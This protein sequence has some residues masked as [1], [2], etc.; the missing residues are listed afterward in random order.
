[1]LTDSAIRRLENHPVLAYAFR[2]VFLLVSAYMALSV[3][4]WGLFWTGFIPVGFH[5]DPLL[6]HMYE[7]I[8]GLASA[9]IIGF[10]LT[11]VP[12]FFH[13]VKPVAGRALLL[14]VLLWCLGRISF[15]LLDEIGPE[16]VALTHLPLLAWVI[17]LVVKP[18]FMDPQ[19]RH[20]GLVL[21]LMAMLSI[22]SWFFAS[23]VGWASAEPKRILMVALG[24]LMVLTLLVIRRVSTGSINTWL[25]QNQIDDRFLA[26]PP[27]YNI[28]IICV[29]L[30]TLAE[31][32]LPA[33]P[34]MGWLGLATCAA[35]LNTLNDFWLKDLRTLLK[36]PILPPL[37]VLLL[38]AC[39]YGLMGYDVLS[40]T[41]SGSNHF[42]HFLTTGAFG[43]AFL[44]VMMI[45]GRI[46]TGRKLTP[47]PWM[48]LGFMLILMASLSRGLI[49]FWPE[50]AWWMY[51][52]AAAGWAVPF[53]IYLIRFYPLLSRP[54]ADGLPG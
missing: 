1:M 19:R 15:W 8:F 47:D 11:A 32:Y 9:G 50:Y 16:G 54:R 10:M 38:M 45:V 36:G 46:H 35:L 4:F 23:L 28:A 13:G 52:F 31:F 2:P 49:P 5:N 39:G 26:R 48:S 42:R 24:A 29:V 3:L 34:I 37:L 6:W 7:M 33:N 17:L 12:E 43:M 21:T 51:L 27:A 25:E 20:W 30:F 41:V 40:P 14:L 53:L 22:Q 18:I 44:L